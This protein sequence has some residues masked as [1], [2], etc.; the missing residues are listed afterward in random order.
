MRKII[1][2]LMLSL[3][4]AGCSSHRL[5]QGRAFR[6]TKVSYSD[7]PGWTDDDL[8]DA[9]PALERA[10]LKPQKGWTNFCA[11][12]PEYKYASSKKLRGYLEKE[13]TPY[14]VTS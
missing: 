13:L 9:Y 3:V 2:F 1:L 8:N 10:C 7:L 14:Q 12:L 11:G 4:V 6:L 5:S